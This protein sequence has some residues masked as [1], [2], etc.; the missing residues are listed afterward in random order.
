VWEVRGRVGPATDA[1]LK[2]ALAGPQ[3]AAVRAGLL[4][5]LSLALWRSQAWA[6]AGGYS[7]SV[8]DVEDFG[9]SLSRDSHPADTVAWSGGDLRVPGFLRGATGRTSDSGP[10]ACQIGD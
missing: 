6:V 10:I 7:H 3:L 2:A 8:A 9:T 1:W 4:L 5:Y